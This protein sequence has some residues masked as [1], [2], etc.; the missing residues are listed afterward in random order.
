MSTEDTTIDIPASFETDW[1]W[2]GGGVAGLIATV[3]MG[4]AIMAMDIEL[5][6]V[7]IAGLYG[8]EESV[9]AGWIAHLAHGT[10][11]GII[12]AAILTDPALYLVSQR[13]WKSVVAGIVYGL[14]LTIIGAGILMPI[15]VSVVGLGSPPI[16][17]V[18]G[19]SL[20]WHLIYGAVLGGIF[21]FVKSL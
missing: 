6:R 5:L 21:P 14:V 12:F 10:L 20:V 13:I 9:V 19:P 4:L 18:T 16:P 7:V 8:F 17:N 15:W 1:A 3:A 2:K 11:F